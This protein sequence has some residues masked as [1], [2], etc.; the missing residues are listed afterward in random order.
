M[1]EEEV[2]Q[3]ETETQVDET[4]HNDSLVST[5][6][7]VKKSNNSRFST[8]SRGRGRPSKASLASRASANDLE[9]VEAP[10]KLLQSLLRSNPP[11][12]PGDVLPKLH[13]HLIHLLDLMRAK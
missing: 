12:D 11:N 2:T 6:T 9:L 8:G 1:P 3:P 13:W 10:E 5:D 4:T 7:V